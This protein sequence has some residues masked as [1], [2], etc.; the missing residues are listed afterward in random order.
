M[1]NLAPL[2][3]S[4]KPD[5]AQVDALKQAVAKMPILR[6]RLISKD[7]RLAVVAVAIDEHTHQPRRT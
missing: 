7:G 6:G 2:I 5:Q 4:D 1:R 3:T